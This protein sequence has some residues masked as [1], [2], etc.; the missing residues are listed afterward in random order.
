MPSEARSRLDPVEVNGILKLRF[1]ELLLGPEAFSWQ[2]KTMST[3][4]GCDVTDPDT[5]ES[6]GKTQRN[7]SAQKESG[8]LGVPIP[9]H[10]NPGVN[11]QFMG[12]F[13]TKMNSG[14]QESRKP[15]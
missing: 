10:M 2:K 13:T 11:P 5:K 15:T 7:E 1:S 6:R 3:K 14:R 12:G 9:D 4:D 8:S